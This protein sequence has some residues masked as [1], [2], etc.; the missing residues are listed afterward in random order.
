MRSVLLIEPCDFDN[1]PIGGQLTF[2]KQMLKAFPDQIALVGISSDDTPVGRWLQKEFHGRSVDFFSI[3][4]RDPS[5]NK[6]FIPSRL[7]SFCQLRRHRG[8]ILSLGIRSVFLQAH[9][10]MLAVWDWDLENV[11]YRFPGTE[12]PLKISR[13]RWAKPFA[14]LFDVLLFS[15]LRRADLILAAGDSSA[16]ES[17]KERGNGRLH[18]KN[19]LPFPT[20]VDTSVFHPRS[21]EESRE[22]L[23]I[24]QESVVVVTTG[25]IHWAKGWDLLL[26]AFCTFQKRASNSLLI[27]V[28]DG[29]DRPKLHLAAQQLGI[30]ERIRVTGYQPPQQVSDFL[31]ASDLF[32]LGSY[33]EGWA[34]SMLEAIACCKP[35]VTTSVS[36]AFD[37]ILEGVTGFIVRERNHELFSDAMAGALALKEVKKTALSIATKYSLTSLSK[38]LPAIWMPLRNPR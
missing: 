23:G 21:R 16:I 20:R 33:T 31:N 3:A 12:N 28:G 18:G 34:T 7:Q 26:H 4:H 11:C 17:L 2:S 6:P 27:F 8:K 5:P 14:R 38:D 1:Y 24:P 10:V 30:A 25:R 36:S 37:L 29:E 15:S 9:E 22:H 32:V 19:I 13:Y 35:V